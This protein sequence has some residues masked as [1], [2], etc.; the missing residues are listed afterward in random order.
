MAGTYVTEIKDI[1]A[2]DFGIMMGVLTIL[3]GAR[4]FDKNK[5][6]DTP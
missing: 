1:A 5:G 3:I 4:S 6:T 2:Q